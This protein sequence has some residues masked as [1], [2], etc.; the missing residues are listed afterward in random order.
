MTQH[1][2]FFPHFFLSMLLEFDHGGGIGFH[3]GNEN[4]IFRQ[5]L[6]IKTRHVR[7]LDLM[8]YAYGLIFS[9]ENVIKLSGFPGLAHSASCCNLAQRS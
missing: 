4:L 2:F 8:S 3:K 9:V 1:L 5:M 6:D 7:K